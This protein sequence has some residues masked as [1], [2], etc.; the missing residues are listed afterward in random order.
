MHSTKI[1]YERD[2]SDILRKNANTNTM[3]HSRW[4]DNI[5]PNKRIYT[6]KSEKPE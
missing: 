3:V 5:G 6:E 4:K 1:N 2:L